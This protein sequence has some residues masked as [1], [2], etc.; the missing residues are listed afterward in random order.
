MSK[1]SIFLV[2]TINESTLYLSLDIDDV[3]ITISF[4]VILFTW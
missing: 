2:R 4:K 3:D 1:L